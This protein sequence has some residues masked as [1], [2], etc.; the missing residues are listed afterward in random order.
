VLE[1]LVLTFMGSGSRWDINEIVDKASM[2]LT[3][4]FK[5]I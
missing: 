3:K 2:V 5:E 1:K 4:L